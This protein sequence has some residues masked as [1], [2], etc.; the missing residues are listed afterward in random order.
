MLGLGLK[1]ALER[2]N[3]MEEHSEDEVMAFGQ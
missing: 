2:Q 3:H 1:P